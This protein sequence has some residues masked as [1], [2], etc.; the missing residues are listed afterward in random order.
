MIDQT[1]P[2]TQTN[3]GRDIRQEW[4][5][6]WRAGLAMATALVLVTV[7]TLS[8]WLFAR[9]L[10]LIFMGLVLASA[11]APPVQRLQR[12]MPRPIAVALIYLLLAL[13]GGG[14]AWLIVPP[15]LGE[16][17][18]LS[19]RLPDLLGEAEGWLA[20][21]GLPATMI[22]LRETVMQ[23]LDAIRSGELI[24]ASTALSGVYETIFAV[25]TSIYWLMILPRLH[26]FTLELMPPRRRE[27]T[28]TTIGAL[29]VAT[30]GYV[31]GVVLQIF[32]IAVLVYA[33]LAIIGVQY[34]LVLAL[35]AGLL[36]A[37]PTLGSWTSSALIVLF[38]L[39]QSLTLGLF[40]LV[41]VAMVQL[42]EGMVLTPLIIGSQAQL[43]ALLVLAALIVGASSGGLIGALV[44]VPLVGA[45]RVLVLRVALPGLR[46]L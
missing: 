9:P 11:L 38:A 28:E 29:S 15:L 5:R 31:R 32:I 1:R 6:W 7:L 12:W 45:L 14:L 22:P 27:A 25:A 26:R 23:Q 24:S 19:E 20:D 30:G 4:A 2:E 34:A 36:E 8:A 43:P 3:D 44:A 33:G 16:F 17:G 42:L 13:I 39:S 35:L 41:F 18:N 40:A 46:R 37:I 21:R 10:A